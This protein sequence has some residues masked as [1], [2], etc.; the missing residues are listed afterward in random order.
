MTHT[1]LL[2]SFAKGSFGPENPN[3]SVP[4]FRAYWRLPVTVKG[5][6]LHDGS[7]LAKIFGMTFIQPNICL[8]IPFFVIAKLKSPSLQLLEGQWHW[9]VGFL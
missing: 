7:T 2:K 3:F 5:L 6:Y 9:E 4:L 8:T 1:A